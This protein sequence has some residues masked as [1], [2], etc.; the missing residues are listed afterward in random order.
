MNKRSL[1]SR[2]S[3]DLAVESKALDR[4]VSV[5]DKVLDRIKLINAFEFSD[6]WYEGESLD[7]VP[8]GQGTYTNASG[9]KYVG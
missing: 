9:E 3:H 1:I 5:V 2:S 8:H 4:T 7:G 6:G